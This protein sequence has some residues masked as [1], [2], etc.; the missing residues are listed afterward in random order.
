MF[1]YFKKSEKNLLREVY[2]LAQCLV[3]LKLIAERR[4]YIC[5]QKMKS[6]GIFFFLQF[7]ESFRGK[8]KLKNVLGE[9]K[10]GL[11][12]RQQQVQVIMY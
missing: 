9:M 10:N 11:T 5:H 2:L 4:V 6:M 12:L 8:Y 3:L 1:S 7:F